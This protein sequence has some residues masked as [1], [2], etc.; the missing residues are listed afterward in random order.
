[1]LSAFGYFYK[2]SNFPFSNFSFIKI[3][4][5]WLLKLLAFNWLSNSGYSWSLSFV[6][7]LDSISI[8][9]K[10]TIF[11]NPLFME[12]FEFVIRITLFQK[13]LDSWFQSLLSEHS[14][15]W[16]VDTVHYQ[17][18]LPCLTGSIFEVT[19]VTAILMGRCLRAGAVEGRGREVPETLLPPLCWLS[20]LWGRGV[21]SPDRE[22]ISA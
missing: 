6:D 12:G 4:G 7:T 11:M 14:D 9:L 10:E 1:M 2:A 3:D 16:F 8:P 13:N 18:S 15:L 17:W 5:C 19:P 22:P 21:V 20:A